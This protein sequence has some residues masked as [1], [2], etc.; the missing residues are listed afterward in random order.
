Y[1][2]T[3]KEQAEALAEGGVDIFAVETMMFP[4]EAIGAIKACKAAAGLPVMATMFFQYE[5]IHDRDRTMWGERPAEV[6]RTLLDARADIVGMNCARGP[7]RATAFLHEMPEV[8]DAPLTAVSAALDVRSPVPV[9]LDRRCLSLR[10]YPDDILRFQ[11]YKKGRDVP[12]ATVL[13]LFD[14]AL[15]LGE[16]LMEP[17]AVYGAAKV[18]RQGPDVIQAGG[19]EFHIPE[20]GRLWGTLAAGGAGI[21]TVGRAI[22][23]RVR[24]LWEEL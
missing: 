15:A 12:D 5:E 23:D 18:T 1:F 21:C 7:D 9:T 19:E 3:V 6:A 11:G 16:S 20:I 10:V 8:T 22:E 13:A 2:A 4:Q 17:R 24:E 14:E